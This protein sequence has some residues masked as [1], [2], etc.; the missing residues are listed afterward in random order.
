MNT[1]SFYDKK[2]DSRGSSTTD[3]QETRMAT[4]GGQFPAKDEHVAS[5]SSHKSKKMKSGQIIEYTS[6]I[7]KGSHEQ[8]HIQEVAQDNRFL[9]QNATI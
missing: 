7:N 9:Q 3:D 6:S 1:A 8:Q 4:G 2:K 5:K